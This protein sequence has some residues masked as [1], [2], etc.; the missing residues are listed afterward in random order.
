M[1]ASFFNYVAPPFTNKGWG[2]EEGGGTGLSQWAGLDRPETG[3]ACT[4]LSGHGS[5]PAVEFSFNPGRQW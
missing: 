1:S 3:K 5:Q 2:V 4:L